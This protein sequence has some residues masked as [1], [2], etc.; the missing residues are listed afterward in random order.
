MI[1]ALDAEIWRSVAEIA[2]NVRVTPTTVLY[3]LRNM[4]REEITERSSEGSW[5]LGP[6]QQAELTQFLKKS[7]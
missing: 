7:R 3:H 6:S 2:A 5:R 4:E 1:Y